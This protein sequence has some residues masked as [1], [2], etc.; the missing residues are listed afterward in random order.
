MA[1]RTGLKELSLWDEDY[2]SAPPCGEFDWIE[3]KASEKLTD[4]GWVDD[5]SKYVSA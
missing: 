3:Y 4:S 2:I 1:A 5:M